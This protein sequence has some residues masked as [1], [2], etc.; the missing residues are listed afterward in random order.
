MLE[1]ECIYDGLVDMFVAGLVGIDSVVFSQALHTDR[2]AYKKI[3]LIGNP[4][5]NI[6]TKFSK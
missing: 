6:P 1:I 4:E 3:E 2:H 5:T